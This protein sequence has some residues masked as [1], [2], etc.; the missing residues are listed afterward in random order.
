MASKAIIVTPIGL[1]LYNLGDCCELYTY[2]DIT[3]L[4][5]SSL[6]EIHRITVCTHKFRNRAGIHAR[7]P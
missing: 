4:E 1:C 6:I 5:F 7:T 3:E 2:H